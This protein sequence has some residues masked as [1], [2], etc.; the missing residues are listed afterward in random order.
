MEVEPDVAYVPVDVLVMD[1]WY[2]R[3]YHVSN[4]VLQPH[5]HEEGDQSLVTLIKPLQLLEVR[6]VLK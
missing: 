2:F 4:L 1:W 5:S 6:D 3:K